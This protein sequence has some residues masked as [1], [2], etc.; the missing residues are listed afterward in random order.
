MVKLLAET[1]VQQHCDAMATCNMVGFMKFFNLPLLTSFK[2]EQLPN[3]A[4]VVTIAVLINIRV[5][6]H[7][8][9]SRNWFHSVPS[10][11]AM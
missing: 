2:V 4:M 1:Y 9:I 6:R 10:C 8:T 7:K 5:S 3:S 11:Y